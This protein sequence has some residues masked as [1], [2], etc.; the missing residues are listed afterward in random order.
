MLLFGSCLA[1]GPAL[2]ARGSLQ[3]ALTRSHGL[4]RGF[5]LALAGPSPGMTHENEPAATGREP[6]TRLYR[7]FRMACQDSAKIST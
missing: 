4:V 7:L 1:C 5:L 3:L 2:A 6:F